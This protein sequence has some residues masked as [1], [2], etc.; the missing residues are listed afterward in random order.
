MEKY[1]HG[2]A[3]PGFLLEHFTT[4]TTSRINAFTLAPTQ[5]AWEVSKADNRHWLLTCRCYGSTDNTLML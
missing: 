4:T 2:V 3:N 1:V 5:R